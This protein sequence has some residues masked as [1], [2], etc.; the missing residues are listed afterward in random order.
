MKK[1]HN[2]AG[3]PALLRA[4]EI[5]L[6]E[7]L[8]NIFNLHPSAMVKE[9]KRLAV[10]EGRDPCSVLDELESKIRMAFGD[11]LDEMIASLNPD[12]SGH[13]Q[14]IPF[15]R[16]MDIEKFFNLR[17][18]QLAHDFRDKCRIEGIMNPSEHAE[19]MRKALI[20]KVNEDTVLNWAL[21]ETRRIL[22]CPP[23]K[24]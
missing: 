20:G 2:L 8:Q 22:R 7:R 15:K 12:A 1:L 6:F 24:A 9:L 4:A 19:E 17:P 14:K 3:S 21:H 5:V 16:R 11:C 23:K 13:L 10:R 18:L